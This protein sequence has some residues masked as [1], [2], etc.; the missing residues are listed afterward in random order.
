MALSNNQLRVQVDTP[1]W[2][3]CRFAPAVSS[4]LSCSCTADNSNFN[5]VS[6]RYIYYL[7]AAAGFWR[8]DTWTDT[9]EQLSTPLNPP[10]TASSMRFAGSQG[11]FGRVISSTAN[12]LQTGLTFGGS[13]KGFKI[14]I[15]SGKGAGQERVI[16][17]VADPVVADYGAATGG[18][19]TTLADTNRTWTSGYVGT[20]LNVNNWV[21]YTVR[22]ILGTGLL[23]LRKVLYN[24]STIITIGDVNKHPEDPWCHTTWTA[25]VA[26]TLYQIESQVI[27][28]DTAWDVQPDNTSRYVIQSGG[29]WLLSGAIATPWFT[30]QYYDVLADVWYVKP[31]LTNMIA[32]APTDLCLERKTENASIWDLGIATGTHSTT[33]MQDTT[34]TWTINQWA[35]YYIYFFSGT[36]KNQIAKITSNTSNTLTFPA[37]TTAPD[38]TSRYQIMGFD[39]G[40]LTASSGN[41]VTDSSKTWTVNQWANFGI[42]ILSGAG[43]GQLRTIQSNTGTVLTTYVGWNVQ[44]DNTSIY[45]IQGDTN[46]LYFSWGGAAEVF[47]YRNGDFDQLSHARLLDM[48]IA[49]TMCAYLSDANHTIYEQPQISIATI[50]RA[51]TVATATTVNSHNLKVGQYVS[52]RGAT[53]TDAQYYDGLV[54]ITTIPSVTT[55]TYTISASAGASATGIGAQTTSV[56]FDA[57]KDHRQIATGGA[58]AATTITFAG[59]T[60]TNING[61][62]VTGTGI[63]TTGSTY[64]QVV[65]GAGTTTLTLSV[66]N[67][68]TVTGNIVTF[69]AWAPSASGTASTGTAGLL[70]VTM[71][72][73]TPTYINGWYAIGTGVGVGATVVSGAGTVNLVLSVVNTATVSGTITFSSPWGNCMV[74]GNSSAVTVTTGFS[75]GQ[76][77]QITTNTGNSLAAITTMAA[78]MTA[79]ASRY[80]IAK[81][82]CLGA[83][84]EGTATTYNSGVATGGSVTTLIDA[85]SFWTQ[86]TG[87]SGSAQSTTITLGAACPSNVTGWYVT[88]TNTAAGAQVV[89]GAGTTTITVSVANSG[90]VGVSIT[91]SAWNTNSLVGKKVKFLSGVT[92]V[93][94]EL[95]ITASTSTTGTLTFVTATAPI[96]NVT[97]YSIIS[98]VTKSTGSTLQWAYGMSDA[99]KRGRYMFS[100]RGGGVAGIDRLDMTTDRWA[101][102]HYAPVIETLTTGSM[103]AYDGTDRLYFTK[104]VTMRVY[105]LD[106]ITNWVHGAGYYPYA[107]GTTSIGNRMEI[108]QTTDGLKYLWLNRHG[109]AECFKQLLFY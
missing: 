66:A 51:A 83:A 60:P 53:G 109:A 94:Q 58:S 24:S 1:A 89:S 25:P 11:Y 6:G 108:Y 96:S 82:D 39:A 13:A 23:Q 12:T 18:S 106:L 86:A 3:W 99:T 79:G 103:Y 91:L 40:T 31:T 62:Y 56:I 75:T 15:I 107:A 17:S 55:F 64:C 95:A 41:T 63:G 88:G 37:L 43:A 78:A 72:A 77:M 32:G 105:Y 80:M 81:R 54:Q 76:Q 87:C 67:S 61:W 98:A 21:G 7:I 22:I 5:T 68:A 93:T 50:T 14:R 38:N 70:T 4:A 92:G 57:G 10:V 90:A 97:S 46:N 34:Q 74:Y 59:N 104:D 85:N 65:S 45:A 48:G 9:Y 30:M 19:T 20:T 47:L 28:V 49:C 84:F 69:N 16:T 73:A 52:I 8:Y 102:M 100:A 26:G 27:T 36:G 2:E 35:N 71:S 29:I 44:P 33:T 101:L 42:R